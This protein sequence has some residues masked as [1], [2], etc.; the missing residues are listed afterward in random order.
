MKHFIPTILGTTRRGRQSE[1]VARYVFARLQ[2]RDTVET[3]LIDLQELDLPIMEERLRF[4]A[5]PPARLVEFGAK[6]ERAD[7]LLVVTPEYNF[8]YPGVLKNALDYLL[9]EYRRKPVGIV[10]VSA[11]PFGG[12]YALSALR[13]AFFGMGAMPI[14][15][16]MPVSRV[17]DA[18][19][20][21]G[22]LTD[23]AYERRVTTFLDELVWFTEA[24]AEQKVKS[25]RK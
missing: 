20:E 4:L 11:G 5:D 21:D 9:P 25:P 18:F 14:P 22:T 12:M 6:I 23:R 16:A 2:E 24:I 17:Q 19:A 7:G 8:G 3:E 13:Q 10:T 1:R 15:A